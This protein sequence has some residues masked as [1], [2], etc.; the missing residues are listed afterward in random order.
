MG[1]KIHTLIENGALHIE[2]GELVIHEEDDLKNFNVD[3]MA[4]VD[5][6]GIAARIQKL[7]NASHDA[8]PPPPPPTYQKEPA[9]VAPLYK[10]NPTPVQEEP[11][12]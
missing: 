6:E 9:Y 3:S 7:Y 2:A 12:V 4:G 5:I 10:M 1:V 11:K 8:P